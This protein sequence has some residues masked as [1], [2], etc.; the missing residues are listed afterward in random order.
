MKGERST[1]KSATKFGQV[2]FG[3]T[4]AT[5]DELNGFEASPLTFTAV[6]PFAENRKVMLLGCG[7]LNP[8]SRITSDSL[9]ADALD[10]VY[11][12]KG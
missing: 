7:R 5:N 12:K 6:H 4:N 11:L 3:A 9:A 1:D 10:G 2:H 8:S